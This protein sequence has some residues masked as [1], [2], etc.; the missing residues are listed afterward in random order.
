MGWADVALGSLLLLS[1]PPLDKTRSGVCTIHLRLNGV[2]SVA[3]HVIY[4]V[5]SFEKTLH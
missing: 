2:E 5:M 3:C 4:A 1:P